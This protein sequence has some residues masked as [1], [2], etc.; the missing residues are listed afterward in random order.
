[1]DLTAISPDEKKLKQ[2]MG[3]FRDQVKQASDLASQLNQALDR[4]RLQ[5]GMA[6]GAGTGRAFRV[7]PVILVPAVVYVVF[8][9]GGG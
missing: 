2:Q 4:L 3:R 9:G 1:M 7:M 6:A 5:T 8:D